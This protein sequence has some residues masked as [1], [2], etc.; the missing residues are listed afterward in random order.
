VQ[1]PL[2]EYDL[3]VTTQGVWPRDSS[4][5]QWYI[6][7]NE[8][9]PVYDGSFHLLDEGRKLDRWAK[10]G[11]IGARPFVQHWTTLMSQGRFND[12]FLATLPPAQRRLQERA[13][14]QALVLGPAAVLQDAGLRQTLTQRDDFRRNTFYHK[15]KEFYADEAVAKH[16][17]DLLQR[18]LDRKDTHPSQFFLHATMPVH[19]QD[20]R[21]VT[22]WFGTQ[23]AGYPDLILTTRIAV[24][25]E[26]QALEKG[27]TDAWRVVGVQLLRA[28]AMPQT[29]GPPTR[30]PEPPG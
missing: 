15:A 26:R 30:Q 7:S 29:K 5:R 25:A 4:Q 24:Q 19:E 13:E 14:C 17:D 1:T 2:V 11:K 6:V 23:I 10:D 21:T 27:E 3:I 28:R 16:L 20:E 22:F 9:T 8:T 18:G 12:A